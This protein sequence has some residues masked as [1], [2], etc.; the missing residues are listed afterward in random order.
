MLAI[1]SRDQPRPGIQGG[2]ALY[3]HDLG[4]FGSRRMPISDLD[5]RWNVA[6]TGLAFSPDN[7]KVAVLFEQ[8][9]NGLLVVLRSRAL[10]KAVSEQVFNPMPVQSHDFSGSAIAWLSNDALLLYGQTIIRTDNGRTIG[11]IGIPNITSQHFSKPDLLEIGLSGT[12]GDEQIAMV[13]LKMDDIDKA[14]TAK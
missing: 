1:A 11:D 10:A 6:P 13:K 14:A 7:S 9:P 12:S 3:V 5:P 2:A 4:Q 8:G